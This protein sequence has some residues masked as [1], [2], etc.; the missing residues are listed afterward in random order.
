MQNISPNAWGKNQN[1]Y[2][3]GG[4]GYGL[5]LH[6]GAVWTRTNTKFINPDKK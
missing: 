5:G 3:T 1:G 2:T 6:V 4:V